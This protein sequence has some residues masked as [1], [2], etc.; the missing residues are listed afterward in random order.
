MKPLYSRCLADARAEPVTRKQAPE[1]LEVGKPD[2][3]MAE[4]GV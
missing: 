3:D 2:A 1:S 4:E